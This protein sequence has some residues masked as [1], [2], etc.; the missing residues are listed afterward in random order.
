LIGC[1]VQVP[2]ASADVLDLVSV[3]D[4]FSGSLNLNPSAAGTLCCI[5][6]LGGG[7]FTTQTNYA[8]SGTAT[9]QI[10]GTTLSIPLFLVETFN[11]NFGGYNLWS[12]FGEELSFRMGFDTFDPITSVLP[13]LPVDTCLAAVCLASFSLSEDRGNDRIFASGVATSF[14]LTDTGATFSG[15]IQE[16]GIFAT[17]PEPSTWAMLLIGFAGIGFMTYR[18]KAKSALLAA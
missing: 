3:G 5:N 12:G 9:L 2:M 17:T 13:P 16:F 1:V 14:T 11:N 10:D 15:S 6:D 4:I 18:R 7:R 8:A